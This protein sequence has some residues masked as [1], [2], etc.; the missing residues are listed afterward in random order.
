[1]QHIF[2]KTPTFEP[3]T[4]NNSNSTVA[5]AHFFAVINASK[6]AILLSAGSLYE[7][8]LV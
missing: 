5:A 4:P 7:V 6:R 2:V 1:M 8:A 3:D